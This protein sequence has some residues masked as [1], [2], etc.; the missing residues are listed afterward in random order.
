MALKLFQRR[1][2][3]NWQIRGTIRGQYVCQSTGTPDKRKAE[4]VRVLAESKLWNRSIYGERAVATFRQIATEYIDSHP[5]EANIVNRLIGHFNAEEIGK[6]GQSQIDKAAK[7]LCPKHS[8]ETVNR[9]IYTPMAAILH[10]AAEAGFCDCI[11]V[12]RPKLKTP[13]NRALSS[14]DMETVISAFKGEQ[15]AFLIFLYYT[16]ARVT[17]ALNL[18]WESV[19]LKRK[20]LVLY[21][22]KT[23]NY[24][25]VHLH[26]RL[27]LELANL[28][29]NEG[30]FVFPWR[31]RSGV[32]KWLRPVIKELGIDFTPHVACHS[33][34][35]RLRE[36][37]HD[38]RKIQEAGGWKSYQSVL[39]YAS[40]S[41]SEIKDAID[42]LPSGSKNRQANKILKN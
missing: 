36:Q 39:R 15:R 11:R 42:G 33:F 23:D 10:R 19:D 4:E 1:S 12:R 30:D 17:E 35:T 7:A 5:R 37:G 3:R 18:K 28:E 13:K 24:R 22:G 16:R 9:H 34:A 20:H 41:S 29:K 40:V 26:E 38:L 14:A 32:Y 8:N 25:G 31:T 2:S 27:F 21:Q 6:I